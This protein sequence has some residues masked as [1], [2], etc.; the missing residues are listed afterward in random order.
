[1]EHF[2]D[3]GLCAFNAEILSI[4]QSVVDEFLP[5]AAEPESPGFTSVSP[6]WGSDIRWVS[7]AEPEAFAIFESAFHKLKIAERLS[8]RINV[9][10][11]IRLYCGSIVLRSEC[12]SPN[13]HCDWRKLNNQAFTMLTPVTH[14]A[15]GF[16]LLY[17]DARGE[18]RDY[19]YK[20]GEAIVFGDWF[21]H[22]TKPGRSERPVALLCFEFGSDRMEDWPKVLS[23]MQTRARLLRRADGAFVRTDPDAHE[24]SY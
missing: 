14:N 24:P 23:E 10:R 4:D 17:R 21:S 16:G 6:K 12:D 19:E 5:L 2:F 15:E 9:E 18:V 11:E 13:F 20:R 1:M 7:A 22:S 3:P 8:K